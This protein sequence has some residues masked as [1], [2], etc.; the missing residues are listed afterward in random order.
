MVD[1]VLQTPGAIRW[2]PVAP[3]LAWALTALLRNVGRV[4]AG[5]RAPCSCSPAPQRRLLGGSEPAAR[6]PRAQAR[7]VFLCARSYVDRGAM[8]NASVPVALVRNLAGN[9]VGPSSRVSTLALE[10][11]PNLTS[12]DWASVSFPTSR[13][14]WH[15]LPLPGSP[16]PDTLM[17]RRR[18][19]EMQPVC[20]ASDCFLRQHAVRCAEEPDVYPLT[21]IIYNIVNQDVSAAGAAAAPMLPAGYARQPCSSSFTPAAVPCP[22]DNRSMRTL[23]LCAGVPQSAALRDVMLYFLSDEVQGNLSAWRLTALPRT[24]AS[25][26]IAAFVPARTQ[27]LHAVRGSQGLSSHQTLCLPSALSEILLL[28][29]WGYFIML[30]HM[31]WPAGAG[32]AGGGGRHARV[33]RSRACR[34]ASSL[35]IPSDTCHQASVC[36]GPP[37]ARRRL[38]ARRGGCRGFRQCLGCACGVGGRSRFSPWRA[39]PFTL[40]LTVPWVCMWGWRTLTLLALESCPLHVGSASAVGAYDAARRSRLPAPG[41]SRER[42]G[43]ERHRGGGQRRRVHRG[44]H[45]RG[46]GQRDRLQRVRR[47]LAHLHAR[48]LAAGCAAAQPSRGCPLNTHIFFLNASV[49]TLGDVAPPLSLFQLLAQ[50]LPSG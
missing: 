49:Y 35:L 3:V 50:S 15:P 30:T 46:A 37:L 36:W 32:G 12:S 4:H 40:A 48:R 29:W 16:L 18:C 39:V 27:Y 23:P 2:A 6:E 17:D 33:R 8:S 9:W 25:T 1:A 41:C 19:P 31:A 45:R 22:V 7:C 28:C 14:R 13:A 34:C 26:F 44:A 5:R 21:C 11:P 24:R 42:A 38:S 10:L 43:V 47:R 20:C